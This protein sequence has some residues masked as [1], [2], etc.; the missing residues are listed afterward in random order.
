M[1]HSTQNEYHQNVSG[2]IYIFAGKVYQQQHDFQLG[3]C[4]MYEL[5]HDMYEYF[6][7]WAW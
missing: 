3:S 6:Y 1:R 4:D 5:W 2:V 7:T